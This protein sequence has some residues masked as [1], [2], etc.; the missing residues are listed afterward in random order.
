M[1]TGDSSVLA[2]AYEWRNNSAVFVHNLRSSPREI[3]LT[4]KAPI[5]GGKMLVNLLSEDHSQP[6]PDGRHRVILEGYGYR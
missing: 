4:V 1:A 3:S 2:I 5:G 6:G